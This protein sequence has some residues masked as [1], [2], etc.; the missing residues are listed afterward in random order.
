MRICLYTCTALPTIGG[1]EYVVDALARQFTALG[2]TAVVLAPR[3][4]H[5]WLQHDGSRPYPVM[6][7]PRYLSMRKLLECYRWWLLRAQRRYGF[8]VLHCHGIYPPGYLAS[9]CRHELGIPCVIT[10]HGGD[11][12]PECPRLSDPLLRP[13]HHQAAV[14][15]D[16]V[17]SISGFTRAN[18]ELLYP[19]IRRIVDIPNGVDVDALA[20]PAPRPAD[21]ASDVRP[22]GYVLFIG[23]LVDRKGVDLALKAWATLSSRSDVKLLIAGDGSDRRS[24]ER[25]AA[26][27][28]LADRVRFVGNRH[29]SEKN[30]LLQNAL[31]TVIP[32]RQWEA[33]PLVVLES[34]A[35]GRPVI[36]TRLLGMDGFVMPQQTGWLVTPES[37]DDL[38]RTF[39]QILADPRQCD[40]Y[41]LQ[42]RRFV[43]D[44]DWCRVAQTHLDLFAELIHGRTRAAA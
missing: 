2:H 42:A 13:R 40:V 33:F 14:T 19:G 12:Y 9:L 39:Q 4:K 17:I 3:S 37:V 24:L 43:Q 26:S 10:S 41:G 20:A 21:L 16:A 36:A 32:S 5:H 34:Y 18:L 15:A 44:F 29:G 8:D 7:H 25:L 22:K 1:Q 31:C 28:G 35:A 23:R 11:V 30:Y 6:R 38:A 27:L